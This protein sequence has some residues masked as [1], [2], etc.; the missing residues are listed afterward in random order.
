MWVGTVVQKYPYDF[1][2]SLQN[3]GQLRRACMGN[4]VN[5]EFIHVG[6]FVVEKMAYDRDLRWATIGCSVFGMSV[7]EI[8][9]AILE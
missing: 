1:N 9:A 2:L 8:G 4:L 7:L 6:I 3:G 5:I